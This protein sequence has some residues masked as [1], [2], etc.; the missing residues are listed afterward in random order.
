MAYGLLEADDTIIALWRLWFNGRKLCPVLTRVSTLVL[1]PGHVISEKIESTELHIC[2]STLFTITVGC[3]IISMA[4]IIIVLF[5]HHHNMFVMANKMG[6]PLLAVVVAGMLKRCFSPDGVFWGGII[7]AVCGVVTVLTLTN[8]AL[9]YYAVANL[10][11]TIGAI[12]LRN[13][14]RIN[15]SFHHQILQPGEDNR[16]G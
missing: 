15:R 10:A 5:C 12:F 11:V 1:Q 9:H 4:L 7:G 16:A 6:N 2:Y 13:A 3:I 14:G 8:L